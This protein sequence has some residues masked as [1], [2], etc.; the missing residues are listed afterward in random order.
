V[1]LASLTSSA[2]AA[3]SRWVAPPASAATA[4]LRTASRSKLVMPAITFRALWALR[5]Q[6]ERKQTELA[7]VCNDVLAAKVHLCCTTGNTV[8]SLLRT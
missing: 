6:P 3:M 7:S 8:R 1:A 4:T 5:L 2:S